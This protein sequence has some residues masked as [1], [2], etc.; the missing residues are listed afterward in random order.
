MPFQPSISASPN[1]SVAA[2]A[3]VKGSKKLHP[4]KGFISGLAA[5][6]KKIPT[7]VCRA[8]K[9]TMKW[10][11]TVGVT[12]VQLWKRGWNA[13]LANSV[14]VALSLAGLAI[15]LAVHQ[16]KPLPEWPRLININS[17]VS[18]FTLFIRA[19]LATILTEGA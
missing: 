10:C 18:I 3:K 14:F 9:S 5:F 13:E 7:L 6:L 17:L 4:I 19:G 2:P 1:H 12:T 15:T 16:D 8:W 11:R